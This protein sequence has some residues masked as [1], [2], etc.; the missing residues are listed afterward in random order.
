LPL[1]TASL[2][3]GL[4]LVY[5]QDRQPGRTPSLPEVRA[6]VTREWADA[7]RRA[8]NEQFYQNLLKRYAIT[9]EPPQSAAQTNTLTTEVRR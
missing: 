3:L 1:V 2:S 9:I 8:S 4:H 6:Q 7:R 5:V